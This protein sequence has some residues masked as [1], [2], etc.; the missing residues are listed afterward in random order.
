M[1]LLACEPATANG[2]VDQVAVALTSEPLDAIAFTRG[3]TPKSAW[4]H[5]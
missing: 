3:K 4:P 2:L 5:Y 1:D